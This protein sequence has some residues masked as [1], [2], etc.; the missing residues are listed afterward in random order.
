[1]TSQPT[2]TFSIKTVAG[3]KQSLAPA[4]AR[5]VELM[6]GPYRCGKTQWLIEELI[7]FCRENPFAG[8]TILVPS[9]RYQTLL[10]ER[11][12]QSLVSRA[13]KNGRSGPLGLVGLKIGS[14]YRICETVLRQAGVSFRVIPDKVRPSLIQRVLNKL[15]R[16]E[17]LVA[18]KPIIHFSGTH[19]SII[20][21]IDE[22][23]RA[24][25]SPE[26]IILQL[27]QTAQSES[28]YLELA[29]IYQAYWQEL[30]ELGY[31]DE[32]GL[33]FK[34]RE[35]LAGNSSA[36]VRLGLLAVDGFDRFNTLQLQVL[37][38]LTEHASRTRICFDYLDKAGNS[39]DPA[40]DYLWKEA[41]YLELMKLF[42]ARFEVLTA[43]P[44][45]NV[46][47]REVEKFRAGDR[48]FEMQE[49]ARQV[50][51]LIVEKNV[52]ANDVL[53]VAR[54]LRPYKAAIAAAFEQAGLAWFVDESVNLCAL[55]MVQF[56]LKLLHLAKDEFQRR[57]VLNCLRSPYLNTDATGMPRAFI[58]RL[59]KI[60]LGLNITGGREQWSALTG[61]LEGNEADGQNLLVF[62]ERIT[63]PLSGLLSDYIAWCE[64]TIEDFLSLQFQDDNCDRFAAYE[65][66]KALAEFKRALAALMH[67]ETILGESDYTRE[68]FLHRLDALVER[69]N[70]RKLPRDREHVTICGADLAPNRSYDYV[71]VAGLAEGEFPRRAT[72]SGFIGADE[73]ARWASFGINIHNP[74]FHPSFEPALFHSLV[75]R[76]R[77]K[78]FLSHP[79]FEL[80]GDELL[81][82][83]FLTGGKAEESSAIRGAGPF[84][85]SLARPLSIRDAL[86]GWLWQG[87]DHPIAQEMLSNPLLKDALEQIAEPLMVARSRGASGGANLYN[88]CLKDLVETGVLQVKMPERWS[89]SKLNDYGQCPFKYWMTHVLKAE[90]LEEPESSLPRR[91]LGELYHKAL[92]LFYRRLNQ[93]GLKLGVAD[94][95]ICRD[96]LTA[97]IAEALLWLESRK[98]VKQG[99][100]WQYERQEI[101]FRLRRFIHREWQRAI[102]DKEGFRP[103]LLEAG[104]GLSE[105]SSAP[106]L[107]IEHKGR[108]ILIRGRVDRIDIADSQDGVVRARIVDYKSGSSAISKEDAVKGRNIQLPLYAMAVEQAI[109]PGSDVVAAA[110]LSVSSGEPIGQLALGSAEKTKSRDGEPAPPM[111]Q[112][113]ER[114][115]KATV[116]GIECGDFSVRPNGGAVCKKCPHS[117]V[118]RVS[119]SGLVWQSQEF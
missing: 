91:I 112:I 52:R 106:P 78:V 46:F 56:L 88:G 18:L 94:E 97:S 37:A 83:F 34:A 80:N 50:K 44:V 117:S 70:I 2:G 3:E 25:L 84:A 72:R 33:A 39:D 104:F 65:E 16:A 27:E 41:S 32:R 14:F 58:E 59:E 67:E 35:V 51:E 47:V 5:P 82:S 114:Q 75:E 19:L 10:E 57:D 48:F 23:E 1:V 13:E 74:R 105:Q 99:E 45:S 86:A 100:F 79:S 66:Q 15:D 31:I 90:P 98:D 71:F 24:A 49:V 54:S 20:D 4:S 111:F 73:V 7:D 87:P 109:L 61:E 85:K 101:E 93:E 26:D 42:N 119:E 36:S 53:V 81:P 17:K 63:P 29:R 60:S 115:V 21:L 108:N 113:V 6:I 89:A 43:P 96:H 107:V 116:D 62:F 92:E 76:A 69:A 102:R 22:F 103:Y 8:A 118:C 77:A 11:V 64:T 30:Q 95:D 38:G 55:P 9:Q 110:Y 40:F 28:R 68:A 12:R